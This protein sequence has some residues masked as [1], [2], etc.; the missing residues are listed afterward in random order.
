[1]R[2]LYFSFIFA[3][4]A[5]NA[6]AECWPIEWGG[7]GT[8]YT[9]GTTTSGTWYVWNCKD[10]KGKLQGTGRI[11]VAGHAPTAGCL[12]TIINPFIATDGACWT[13]TEEEVTKYNRLLKSMQTAMSKL[14]N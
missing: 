13:V 9:V 7:V 2:R 8:S 10:A 4:L 3:L 5:G 6:H 14:P 1:M 11:I 12:A